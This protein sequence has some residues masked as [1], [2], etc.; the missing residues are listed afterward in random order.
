MPKQT[1]ILKAN[2]ATK[3]QFSDDMFKRLPDK[4]KEK[5]VLEGALQSE[6]ERNEKR[7]TPDAFANVDGEKAKQTLKDAFAELGIEHEGDDTAADHA[8]TAAANLR[9]AEVHGNTLQGEKEVAEAKN[10][11]LG[12]ALETAKRKS[13]GDDAEIK[14]LTEKVTLLETGDIGALTKQLEEA[15]AKISELEAKKKK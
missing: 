13:E 12:E 8:L 10:V 11:E 1:Y 2:P 3:R 7:I 4:E 5:W 9:L 14:K 15:N 6:I